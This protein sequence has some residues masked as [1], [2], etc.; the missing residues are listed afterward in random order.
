[1]KHVQLAKVA[2]FTLASFA[3][4]VSA[5]GAA[6]AGS[7]AGPS[8]STDAPASAQ[9][10]L[11][12]AAKTDLA[13][14]FG[15]PISASTLK[16]ATRMIWPDTSLGCSQRGFMNLQVMTPGFLIVLSYQGKNYEYHSDIKGPPFLCDSAKAPVPHHK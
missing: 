8:G 5:T 7:G 10:Q 2:A 1:M 3:L 12:T 6:F 15:V 4:V 9:E 13:S 16:S 14:R 11:I